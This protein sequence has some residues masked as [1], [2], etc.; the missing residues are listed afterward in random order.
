MG[1]DGG[2]AWGAT[3]AARGE[4]RWRRIGHDGQGVTDA[5]AHLGGAWAWHV[6]RGLADFEKLSWTLIAHHYESMTP[7]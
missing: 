3:V 1:R 5:T 2:G 7:Q 6:A 4:R